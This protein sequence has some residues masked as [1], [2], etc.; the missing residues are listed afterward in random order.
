MEK[1]KERFVEIYQTHIRREGADKLL[2]YL[3]SPASDFFHAPAST[4]FH[5]AYEG[6]LAQHSLNVYDCLCD[7]LKRERVKNTYHLEASEETIAGSLSIVGVSILPYAENEQ[8]YFVDIYI[9][10]YGVV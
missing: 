9:Y 6:G 7:Y 1:I 8:L 2:E 5:S 3:L 4:R 10:M